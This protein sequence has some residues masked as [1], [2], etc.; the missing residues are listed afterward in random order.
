MSKRLE[1][2]FYNEGGNNVTI[3]IDHPI[4]PVEPEA[5]ST[6]MDTMMSENIFTSSDGD[7]TEKRFA[8]IVERNVEIIELDNE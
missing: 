3:G 7:L 1:L 4:E 8:R 5:V 2:L 6:V